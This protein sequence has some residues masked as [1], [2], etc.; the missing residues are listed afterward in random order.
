M[1]GAITLCID[2][3]LGKYELQSSVKNWGGGFL[4][5]R[6]WMRFGGGRRKTVGKG[7][8]VIVQSIRGVMHIII[9]A[10]KGLATIE[11]AGVRR[12]Q[13]LGAI[14]KSMIFVRFH[15]I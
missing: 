4:W 14:G 10:L 12:R 11:T 3:D 6:V 9:L 5:L 8:I 15:P 7:P 2:F 13:S 1:G